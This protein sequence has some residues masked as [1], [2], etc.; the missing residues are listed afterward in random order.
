MG[1]SRSLYI[2]SSAVNG[3][4]RGTSAIS[5][6]LVKIGHLRYMPESSNLTGWDAAES[7]GLEEG[8]AVPTPEGNGETSDS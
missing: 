4:A 2:S 6:T 5:P 7:E 8:Y 1:H 3:H